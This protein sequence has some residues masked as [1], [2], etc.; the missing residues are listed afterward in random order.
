MIDFN[1][2][3]LIEKEE[4]ND[5][6]NLPNFRY[7]KMKNL[8]IQN[9]S[10]NSNKEILNRKAIQLLNSLE[11][12]NIKNLSNPLDVFLNSKKYQNQLKN[13]KEDEINDLFY[14]LYSKIQWIDN[15]NQ[16]TNQDII[17]K[18]IQINQLKHNIFFSE[19]KYKQKKYQV[20]KFL[21]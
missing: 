2:T 18:Q 13:S 17:D 6:K 11:R 3:K 15:L 10:Q 1:E 12:Y 21:I 20:K 4:E 5:I 7:L 16:K 9:I 8:Q 19:K 14:Q